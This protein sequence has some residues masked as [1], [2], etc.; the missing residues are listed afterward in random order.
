MSKGKTPNPVKN[1]GRV[2]NLTNAG[3]GRAKGVPNKASREMKAFCRQFLERP[4]YIRS[5]T[6][7]VDAG[8][9]PHMETLLHHYGYGKPAQRIEVGADKSLASLIT[10]AVTGRVESSREPAIDDV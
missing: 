4:A 3:K 9:A 6:R 1:A 5:L 2:E 8:T 7:R 10:E